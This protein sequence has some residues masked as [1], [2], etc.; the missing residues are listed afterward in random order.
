MPQ[1]ANPDNPNR[2]PRPGSILPQRRVNRHAAAE[3]WR[4]GRGGQRIGNLERKVCRPAPE[5][6]EPAVCFALVGVAAVVGAC[7]AGAV[8]L[9]AAGA[10]L[11]VSAKAGHAL[12]ADADAV[13]DFDCAGGGGGG[14]DGDA[15]A[16]ADDRAD[17]LVADDAGVVAWAPA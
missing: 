7:D 10:G 2:L 15:A 8:V 4:C 16:D 12:G 17:Y 9:A 5:L 1:P 6:R 3:Q 13:A 14:E 11:A